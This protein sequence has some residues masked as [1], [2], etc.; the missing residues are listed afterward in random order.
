MKIKHYIIGAVI[1][2][3]LAILFW[4][5]GGGGVPTAT[6]DCNSNYTCFE[7]AALQ[8]QKAKVTQKTDANSFSVEILGQESGKCKSI[9][10]MLSVNKNSSTIKQYPNSLRQEIFAM[11]G[12][13][14]ACLMPLEVGIYNITDMP[15]YCSGSLKDALVSTGKKLTDYLEL[16]Y[17][18]NPACVEGKLWSYPETNYTILG[19]ER[20]D[21]TDVCHATY[22]MI[23]PGYTGTFRV[24]HYFTMDS[25][26]A[27]VSYNNAPTPPAQ[28]FDAWCLSAPKWR[29]KTAYG[30]SRVVLA[31]P[32]EADGVKS[33][34]IQFLME[35][36][37]PYIPGGTV[38]LYVMEGAKTVAT[39]ETTAGNV[40]QKAYAP[41]K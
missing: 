24:H 23:I 7:Q 20:Y 18:V 31:E 8:C 12:K 34:H 10:K 38:D 26:E 19:I 1:L 11:E 21:G 9:F 5:A 35:P 14:M 13:D 33:C 39:F 17:R 40:L 29:Y 25:E 4:P 3:L 2:G 28:N 41:V 16:L 6:I 22:S 36:S 27:E 32:V 37:S 15:S 30:L